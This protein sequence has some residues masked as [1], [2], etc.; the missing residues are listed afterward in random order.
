MVKVEASLGR[1]AIQ[2]SMYKILMDNC[3]FCK[4]IHQRYERILNIV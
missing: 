4:K 1:I 2:K 3:H